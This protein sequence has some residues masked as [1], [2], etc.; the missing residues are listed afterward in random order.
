MIV[1]IVLKIYMKKQILT[2]L[3]ACSAAMLIPL[4]AE[5]AP[6]PTEAALEITRLGIPESTIRIMS[7][8]WTSEEEFRQWQENSGYTTDRLRLQY[9]LILDEY[10]TEEELVEVVNFLD[11]PGGKRFIEMFSSKDLGGSG[12]MEEISEI[13]N[14]VYQSQ[15]D[16]LES[17]GEPD[18]GDNSE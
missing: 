7:P 14:E 3:I 9:A 18:E 10:Y 6:T 5:N 4:A 1:L 17:K 8:G 12:V 15:S 13:W 11:S 16:F 2:L